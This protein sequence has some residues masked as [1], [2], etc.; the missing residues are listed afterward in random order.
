MSWKVGMLGGP[1]LEAQKKVWEQVAQKLSLDFQFAEVSEAVNADPVQNL[2]NLE[3]FNA[4]LLAPTTAA[5]FIQ[6]W[7]KLPSEVVETG[8]ADA[9]FYDQKQWWFR[10]FLKESMRQLIIEKSPQLDTHSLAYVTGSEATA[11]L[12]AAVVAQMGFRR[13]TFIARDQDAIQ[14]LVDRLQRMYFDLE[15]KILKDT[16]LT[17]QPSNGSILLNCLAAD[18]GEAML[19]DLPYLNFLK[20]DGLVVDLP[21]PQGVKHLTEEADHVGIRHVDGFELCVLRDFLFLQSLLGKAFA[22]SREEHREMWKPF[23]ETKSE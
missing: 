21:Y 15:V 6:M 16:E 14:L 4:L 1:I 10:S 8:F 9:V 11:R 12:C 18:S 7:P 13:I 19:D 22:L 20:K 17:L 3:G 23:S 2:K 5:L